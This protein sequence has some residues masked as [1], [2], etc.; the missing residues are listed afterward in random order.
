[1]EVWRVPPKGRIVSFR[2]ASSRAQGHGKAQVRE[3]IQ[4]QWRAPTRGSDVDVNAGED[5]VNHNPSERKAP[6]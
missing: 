3:K 1:M 2:Q 5:D 4:C 6:N